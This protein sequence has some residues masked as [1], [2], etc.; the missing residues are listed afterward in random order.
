MFLNPDE[1]REEF[2]LREGDTV[3][4]LGAGSGAYA[5]LAAEAVGE[6]GKVYAIDVQRDF[7]PNIKNSA[8]SRGLKNVEVM[9]GD[10]EVPGGS[11]LRDGIADAVILANTL[12][13]LDDKEGAVKEAKRI[14][15][16]GGKLIVI[17]WEDSFGN[18]GP[19]KSAVVKKSEA[20]ELFRSAGFIFAKDIPAGEYHYGL[21]FHV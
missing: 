8:L 12:F 11:G 1:H 13:Q 14:L 21:L 16:Q 5:F 15:K 6:T 9:W 7:L 3:A 18:M 4:D 2:G 10:F 17:D 20:V 19:S